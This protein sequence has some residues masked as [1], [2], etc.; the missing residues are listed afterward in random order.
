MERK[1]P[2]DLEPLRGLRHLQGLVLHDGYENLEVLKELRTLRYVGVS[3]D[4]IDESP[5]QI[6]AIRQ[7][8][9]DAVVVR[10]A[11]FCLGSGW[12]LLLI[13]VLALAWRSLR[14]TPGRMP[15]AA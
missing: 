13:P 3:E 10:I 7:A 4:L 8:L 1:E 5:A 6:A 12:I 9:P 15:A 14:R 11:P 2:L